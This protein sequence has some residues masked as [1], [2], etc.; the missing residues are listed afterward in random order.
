MLHLRRHGEGR[1]GSIQRMFYDLRNL[2][3]SNK[4]NFQCRLGKILT[5]SRTG[6][7]LPY[8]IPWKLVP[9]NIYLQLRFTLAYRFNSVADEIRAYYRTEGVQNQEHMFNLKNV[10][11]ITMTTPDTRLPFA[12]PQ[13]VTECG[14]IVLDAEKVETVD[15][16]LYD[17]MRRVPTVLL[18]LGSLMKYDEA[19]AHI[20]AQAIFL[21]LQ[22]TDVQVLWKFSKLGRYSD[23]YLQPLQPFLD[24]GRLRVSNWLSVEPISLLQSGQIVL[25]VHHGGAN[26]YHEAI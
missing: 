25:S 26:S 8:P 16:E 13:H 12:V 9:I 20:M 11:V 23:D 3:D 6:S 18:N 2:E 15:P 24:N 17:W 1:T 21:V 4:Q 5:C 14:S 19:R 22:S 10:S 7:A